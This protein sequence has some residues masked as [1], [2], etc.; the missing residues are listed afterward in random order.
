MMFRSNKHKLISSFLEVMMKR[1]KN[2][3]TQAKENI[4]ENERTGETIRKKEI[5]ASIDLQNIEVIMKTM[6]G[7]ITGIEGTENGK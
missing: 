4:E 5:T 1:E 6:K 3:T 7:A 2:V